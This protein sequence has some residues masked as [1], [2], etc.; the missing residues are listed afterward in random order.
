MFGVFEFSILVFVPRLLQSQ[1]YLLSPKE[2]PEISLLSS[3]LDIVT[4][5]HPYY[6]CPLGP[7]G[8]MCNALAS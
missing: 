8:W 3:L 2:D 6:P 1:G 7:Q 4:N 5:D